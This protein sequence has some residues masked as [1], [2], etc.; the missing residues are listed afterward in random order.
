MYLCNCVTG[1][2]VKIKMLFS[3]SSLPKTVLAVSLFVVG[4]MRGMTAC[5]VSENMPISPNYPTTPST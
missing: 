1:I 2:A 3:F 4:K 5:S